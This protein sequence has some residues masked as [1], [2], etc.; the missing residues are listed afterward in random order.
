MLSSETYH[1][2]LNFSERPPPPPP[3]PPVKATLDHLIRASERYLN[4]KNT[5]SIFRFSAEN[6]ELYST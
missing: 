1:N 4:D 6:F 3:P 5:A 2:T